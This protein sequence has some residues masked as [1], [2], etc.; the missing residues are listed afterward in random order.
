MKLIA[1]ALVV[2]VLCTFYLGQMYSDAMTICRNNHS[3]DY[4]VTELN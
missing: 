3:V 1:I 4:C 2:A